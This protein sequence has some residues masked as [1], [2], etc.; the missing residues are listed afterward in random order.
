MKI[1]TAIIFYP[2][3]RYYTIIVCI[4]RPSRTTL[5]D[6]IIVYPPT[7]TRVTLLLARFICNDWWMNY[8][9]VNDDTKTLYHAIDTRLLILRWKIPKRRE[10]IREPS[11]CTGLIRATLQR[12]QKHRKY[13]FKVILNLK[14]TVF[15]VSTGFARKLRRPVVFGETSF[16]NGSTTPRRKPEDCRRATGG[17]HGPWP[18]SIFII[19]RGFVNSKIIVRTTS[20]LLLRRRGLLRCYTVGSWN[21]T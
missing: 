6:I 4:R 11:L 10:P 13:P 19:S 15:N 20:F 5:M 7:M 8:F 17:G 1:E 14:C 2:P 12:Q 9:T 3:F 16:P 21:G 18:L